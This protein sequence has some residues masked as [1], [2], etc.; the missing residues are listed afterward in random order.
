[1]ATAGPRPDEQGSISTTADSTGNEAAWAAGKA[2]R[3]QISQILRSNWIGAQRS[4]LG[5]LNEFRHW[6]PQ[7]VRDLF[8]KHM[9]PIKEGNN[10][11]D[12]A[13]KLYPLGPLYRTVAQ[14]SKTRW[15][16]LAAKV[17]MVGAVDALAI[18]FSPLLLLAS[19]EERKKTLQY[20]ADLNVGVISSSFFVKADV[21]LLEE[22]AQSG[23][24]LCVNRW[25]TFRIMDS[26]YMAISHVWAE[27][28]ALES[29]DE[30]TEQDERGLNMH[31]F[32]RT[33]DVVR[34][35][36]SGSEW[37]WFDLLAIPKG[38]DAATKVLKTKLINNLRH[39]YANATAIVVLDSLTLQLNCAGD[40]LITAAV[41]S[42]GMWLSR[43][44][45]YQEAKLAQKLKIVTA[46]HVVDFEDMVTALSTA[47]SRDED[48]WHQIYL[49]FQRL[50]PL[51]QQGISLA[52]I[53]L[54]CDHRSCE[55]EVDYARGFFAL[56]GLEWKP[57][58]TYEDGMLEILRSQ[59][60]H[61][62]RIAAMHGP[63]GLPA[64]YS[65]APK[66]LARLEGRI[67][68]DLDAQLGSLV[69]HWY[70]IVVKRVVTKFVPE[71]YDRWVCDLVVGEVYDDDD[72]S[73]GS[74]SE[75]GNTDSK[76]EVEAQ[77]QIEFYPS[78]WT[79]AL[80]T[81][82]NETIPNGKA[83]L[84][85]GEPLDFNYRD[86]ADQHARIVLVATSTVGPVADL[87]LSDWGTVAGSAVVNSTHLGGVR[88]TRL[89][90]LLE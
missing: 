69:G 12:E 57:H 22:A 59:P 90:W 63:R 1:M 68:G 70:T 76:R 18:P 73:H 51:H 75:Q 37:V 24:A 44:W 43:V 88:E 40:P 79:P 23:K 45:T 2:R 82:L 62:A 3:R 26:G 86:T 33:M 80:E 71:G 48:R 52:D 47:Q 11:G 38:H 35:C 64:P 16:G 66:Y 54:S 10:N 50:V 60:R 6:P 67:Y 29:H 8:D 27:T 36:G 32:I 28:M 78:H 85:C 65:W 31:H 46:T 17:A 74:A 89:R 83:R 49:T 58:Y 15:K 30:K 56:L 61:A 42:C 87:N 81:W 9:P 7:E 39:V 21:R 13:R 4:L 84:L 25:G 72:G 41:L 14:D 34:R 77:I 5:S 55:N 19:K 53:A 20:M